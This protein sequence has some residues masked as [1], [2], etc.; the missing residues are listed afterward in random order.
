MTRDEWLTSA[1]PAA[2]LAWLDPSQHRVARRGDA[3]PPG[4]S[5]RKLRLYA[6]ALFREIEA[7]GYGLSDFNRNTVSAVEES[8]GAKPPS[9]PAGD[10]W[11][12][13]GSLRRDDLAEGVANIL[14][15]PTLAAESGKSV[16]QRRQAEILRDTVGDPF[17]PFEI[18]ECGTC[19]GAGR[20]DDPVGGVYECFACGGDGHMAPWLTPQVRDL[21]EAAYLCREG[22]EG[23]R[24]CGG[25][26]ETHDAYPG[27]WERCPACHG[28]GHAD[29]G[30]GR[31]DPARLAVLADALEEAGAIGEECPTCGG[32]GEVSQDH[33]WGDT[34]ATEWLGCHHCEGHGRAPHPLLAA[35]RSPG[36]RYRGF[37][38]ID[39]LLGKE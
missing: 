13:A 5:D 10:Y 29:G 36:P 37:W 15:T 21:A 32:K 20:L 39:V 31:L 2:M 34:W 33:P 17:A 19:S 14:G 8:P 9:H 3:D 16:T 38:A 30:T 26:G 28:T 23:C 1:D 18:P 7:G 24:A 25:K 22:W 12:W 6:C 35:L 4:A 11:G 27:G